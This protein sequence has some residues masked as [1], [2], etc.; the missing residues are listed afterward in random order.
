MRLS[1][2]QAF[3]A[4]SHESR[5]S[6]RM[7]NECHFWHPL[8]SVENAFHARLILLL[9][10]HH[11]VICAVCVCFFSVVNVIR[12]SC[13]KLHSFLLRQPIRHSSDRAL[14]KAWSHECRVNLRMGNECH[15]QAS[16]ENA[17]HARLILLLDAHHQSTS[18]AFKS[19]NGIRFSCVGLC[20]TMLHSCDQALTDK[21]FVS[22]FASVWYTTILKLSL[23]LLRMVSEFCFVSSL[24]RVTKTL[25]LGKVSFHTCNKINDNL[26]THESHRIETK[27]S[28]H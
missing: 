13:V 6:L 28:D 27:L 11:Q 5:I 26:N 19:L 12:F 7:R 24:I 20:G 10:A 3:K 9:D 17:F 16:D 1:C 14:I 18:F 21:S 23:L 25:R 4:L 2:D 15:F 8:I 22:L